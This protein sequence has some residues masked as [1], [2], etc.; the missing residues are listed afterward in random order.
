MKAKIDNWWGLMQNLISGT[1]TMFT[2]NRNGEQSKRT[3]IF[4]KEKLN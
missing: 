1:R 2:F 4:K 3:Y